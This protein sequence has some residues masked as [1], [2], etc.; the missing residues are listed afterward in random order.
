MNVRETL[1]RKGDPEFQ[2]I[3]KIHYEPQE[4]KTETAK[5]AQEPTQ[6]QHDRSTQ[7][8]QPSS[9]FKVFAAIV[10]A[11]GLVLLALWKLIS[12]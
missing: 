11:G 6:T 10:A 7:Q 2:Q 1:M 9:N 4:L 12:H 3:N 8:P 5:P